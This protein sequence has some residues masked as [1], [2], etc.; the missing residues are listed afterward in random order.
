[1]LDEGR[2]SFTFTKPFELLS[3]AVR[4]TNSSKIGNF[5]KTA[6]KIFEPTKMPELSLRID[7]SGMD[8]PIWLP[9]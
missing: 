1:M 2:L 8:R 9:G 3:K 7:N 5:E 6:N 4:S